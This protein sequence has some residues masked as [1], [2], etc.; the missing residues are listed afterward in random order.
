M[1]RNAKTF[2]SETEGRAIEEAVRSAEA[3]TAGEIVVMV[4]DTSALYRE[5]AVLGAVVL[6]VFSALAAEILVRV[7]LMHGSFWAEGGSSFIY[8]LLTATATRISV[9][10]FIPLMIVSFYIWKFVITKLP[11][12]KLLFVSKTRL[13]EAVREG[14]V[15]AFYEKGLYRTRDET[16]I[17][18]YISLHERRVWILGDRG[19]NG[20]IQPDFWG[21]LFSVLAQSIRDGRAGAVITSVIEKCGDELARHFPRKPDDT[22]ELDNRPIY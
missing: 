7:F 8:Q 17:L 6:G 1:K 5:A 9:W 4:A 12:L 21:S 10:T 14:A 2:F 15:R 13:E 11:R 3:K 22:D 16:G 19:I 18:I 20:K